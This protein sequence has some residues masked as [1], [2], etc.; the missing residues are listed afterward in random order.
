MIYLTRTVGGLAPADE[1][2]TEALRRIKVGKLVACEVKVPRNGQFHRKFLALVRTVWAATG[3]WAS[4]E[5][6]LIELKF[7]LGVIREVALKGTG[8]IVK[9]PGSISFAAM[10]EVEFSK[11]YDRAM[12]ELCAMA[13]GIEYDALRDEVLQQ[14]A[15]A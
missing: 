5:D 6:L 7:R 9:I 12:R 10:D 8:E 13:G 4:V 14:L 15:A 1:D 2:A 11:F 3:D